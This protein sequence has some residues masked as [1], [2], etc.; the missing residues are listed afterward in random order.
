MRWAW[1]TISK[2]WVVGNAFM[3][4]VYTAF[5]KEPRSIAFAPYKKDKAEKKKKNK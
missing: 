4:S 1:L 5:R 2:D 3:N